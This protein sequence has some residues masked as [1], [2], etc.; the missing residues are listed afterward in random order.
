MGSLALGMLACNLPGLQ[1]TDLQIPNSSLLATADGEIQAAVTDTIAPTIGLPAA[2]ATLGQ[3]AAVPSE[4]PVP[5]LGLV[6]VADVVH[7]S[8]SE[9]TLKH[10]D[11]VDLDSG[12]LGVRLGSA[13]DFQMA[14]VD[15]PYLDA[16]VPKNGAYI[17]WYGAG[18]QPGKAGCDIL[19]GAMPMPL[20]WPEDKDTYYCY[21]TSEGRTGWL[22]VLT[23]VSQPFPERRLIFSF[24]TYE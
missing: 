18:P 22:Q 1:A 6:I 2:T 23:Y 16:L 4:T 12:S 10:D 20:N 15:D 14:T 8:G 11:Y 13:A 9:L 7:A 19:K 24:A 3:I 5:T 21:Q 17:G